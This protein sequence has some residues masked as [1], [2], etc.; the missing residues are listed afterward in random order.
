[1]KTKI[2]LIAISLLFSFTACSTTVSDTDDITGETEI[3]VETSTN[4]NTD[5]EPEDAYNTT[6]IERTTILDPIELDLYNANPTDYSSVLFILHSPTSANSFMVYSDINQYIVAKTNIGEIDNN[7]ISVASNSTSVVYEYGIG[8]INTVI[9]HAFSSSYFT[10]TYNVKNVTDVFDLEQ[11]SSKTLAYNGF[12]MDNLPESVTYC[13]STYSYANLTT[14][15]DYYLDRTDDGVIA[16]EDRYA[17]INYLF[18]DELTDIYFN[19]THYTEDNIIPEYLYTT[20][21]PAINKNDITETTID[22]ATTVDTFYF[23]ED[24]NNLSEYSVFIGEDIDTTLYDYPIYQDLIAQLISEYTGLNIVNKEYFL[25]TE[26]NFISYRA[27]LKQDDET[28]LVQAYISCINPTFSDVGYYDGICLYED[29]INHEDYSVYNEYTYN[30][31]IYLLYTPNETTL[32]DSNEV[33][34]C[35]CVYDTSHNFLGRIVLTI[36]CTSDYDVDACTL[37]QYFA[38]LFGVNA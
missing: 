18:N 11:A 25:E 21:T 6:N 20:I 27:T 30:D 33:I 14:E 38:L 35:L 26:C 3:E 31:Y 17:Y 13:D 10:S 36:E 24:I 22:S 16:T 2:L 9:S 1:M 34:G 28:C 4:N 8:N 7:F 37:D 23:I 5:A 15:Y 32:I 19:I 12:D 29:M